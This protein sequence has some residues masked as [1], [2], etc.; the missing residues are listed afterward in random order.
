MTIYLI[1]FSLIAFFSLIELFVSKQSIKPLFWFSILGLVLFVGLRGEEVGFDYSVYKQAFAEYDSI[2][3]MEPGYVLL[4][5]LIAPFGSFSLLLFIMALG[6]ISMKSFFI[7]RYSPYIFTGLLVYF[8]TAMLINDMGQIRFGMAISFALLS[9]NSAIKEHKW[10]MWIFW[11]LALMFH[12]SAVIVLP[13]LLLRNYRF[14]PRQLIGLL[15][16]G[17]S[18]FAL[19]INS[20]LLSIAP[21]LPAHVAFKIQFYTFYTDTFGEKLG[22]NI[23]LL[24]RFLIL[25]LFFYYKDSFKSEKTAN[26][27]FNLYFFGIFIYLIFNGNAEFAIRT[28]GYFKILELVILPIFIQLGKTRVDKLI[29]WT[30]VVAYAFYSLGKI[31]FDIDF[32]GA[33]LDYTNILF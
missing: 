24:L 2:H 11:G 18:F 21:F 20:I 31:L 27:F 30:L 16:I 22:L 5:K 8:S 29:I 12:Y 25:G 33:Y 1:I 3:L 13:A 6:A 9:F 28:S 26:V 17:F 14:S 32:G 15:I 19:N 10:R 23:S 4:N 7:S